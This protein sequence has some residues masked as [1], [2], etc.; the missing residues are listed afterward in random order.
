[1][2]TPA[3]KYYPS[4]SKT[5]V[6]LDRD[7]LS[8]LDPMGRELRQ[9]LSS[10]RIID[11]YRRIHCVRCL[12]SYTEFHGFTE[13]MSRRKR[14]DRVMITSLIGHILHEFV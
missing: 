10:L 6:E 12:E 4:D 1:M 11:F 3:T 13:S 8:V 5:R 7:V 9:H 14:L 2:V